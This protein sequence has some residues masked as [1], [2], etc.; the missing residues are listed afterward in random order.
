MILVDTAGLRETAEPVEAAGIRR[1]RARIDAADLVLVL[2]AGP[3]APIRPTLGR[4]G[5]TS[6]ACSPSA[7]STI[8]TPP[9]GRAG[10]SA[11]TGAGLGLDA[12]ARGRKAG[13]GGSGAATP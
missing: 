8:R 5:T 9:R 12:A 6:R 10:V 3:D 7:T 1:A 4:S 13:R 11:K 2:L